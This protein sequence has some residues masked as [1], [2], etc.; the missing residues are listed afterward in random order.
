MG[1]T[2][3]MAQVSAEIDRPKESRPHEGNLGIFVEMSTMASPSFDPSKPGDLGVELQRILERSIIFSKAVD[4]EELCVRVSEQAW[5]ISLHVQILSHDGNILDCA[6]IASIAALS[7]FKRPDV[8]VIGKDVQI[9]TF[10][11]KNPVSL[12]FNHQPFCVTFTFFDNGT[13][14]L[15]DPTK[16]EENC[17]DGKLIVAVNKH[18][19]V[20]C[21]QMS[22][23]IQVNSEQVLRCVNNATKKAKEL[24]ELVK[25]SIKNDIEAKK[26]NMKSSMTSSRSLTIANIDP[27]PKVHVMTSETK[28]IVPTKEESKLMQTEITSKPKENQKLRWIIKNAENTFTAEDN[29]KKDEKFENTSSEQMDSDEEE[30]TTVT[31]Q[32]S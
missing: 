20:C 31:L 18:R 23:A 19:E 7:H 25:E 11:E 28:V 22:G 6:S 12:T 16:L 15:T 4:F 2:K 24:T 13:A 5:N 8:T 29:A 32:L 17:C 3:V 27:D 9:H 10:E 21:T 1:K 14:L 26:K 30:E